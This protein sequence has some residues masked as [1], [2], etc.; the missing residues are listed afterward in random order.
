MA[1]KTDSKEKI[2]TFLRNKLEDPQFFNYCFRSNRTLR[3]TLKKWGAFSPEEE[4]AYIH[5]DRYVYTV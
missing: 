5:E 3:D 2:E 1:N 4:L